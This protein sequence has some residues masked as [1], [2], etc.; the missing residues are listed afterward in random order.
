MERLKVVRW[1]KVAKSSVN[2]QAWAQYN[3]YLYFKRQQH[4]SFVCG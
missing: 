2:T 4:C 1:L 3:T